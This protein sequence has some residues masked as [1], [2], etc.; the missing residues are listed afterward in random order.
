MPVHVDHH[1]GS[2]ERVWKACGTVGL[3]LHRRHTRANSTLF[4]SSRLDPETMV[5]SSLLKAYRPWASTKGKRSGGI[6]R[7]HI[8]SEFWPKCPF[9]RETCDGSPVFR[10]LSYRIDCLSQR[11]ILC[12]IK[13]NASD[14]DPIRWWL[15]PQIKQ[16]RSDRRRFCHSDKV[17]DSPGG[18][19]FPRGPSRTWVST[20]IRFAYLVQGAE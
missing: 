9:R 3:L 5:T 1:T 13:K 20:I 19:G 14:M 12:E 6:S 17:P 18:E 8:G 2:R 4:G 7:L 16:R 10:F 11:A 15:K